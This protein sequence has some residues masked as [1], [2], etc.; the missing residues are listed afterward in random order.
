MRIL[1]NARGITSS[2]AMDDAEAAG[3]NKGRLQLFP[4]LQLA[5]VAL[6]TQRRLWFIN[7]T[8]LPLPK[9]FCPFSIVDQLESRNERCP[10]VF[11]EEE[12]L[13]G[14]NFGTEKA[15]R[16]TIYLDSRDRE[17]LWNCP[18]LRPRNDG[19]GRRV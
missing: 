3:R 12:S 18:M 15:H 6:M 13:Q 7:T 14:H 5:H 19:A 1:P 8:Q 4:L 16:P 9:W 10:E 17:E 2:K 11:C